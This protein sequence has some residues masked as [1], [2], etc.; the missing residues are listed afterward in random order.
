MNLTH[1]RQFRANY[2]FD[3]RSLSF[4]FTVP[5]VN[6]KNKIVVIFDIMFW[7]EYSSRKLKCGNSG[8]AAPP[9]KQLLHTNKAVCYYDVKAFQN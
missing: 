4:G 1:K 8:S 2:Y 3:K 9:E 5:T 7:Y 6:Q